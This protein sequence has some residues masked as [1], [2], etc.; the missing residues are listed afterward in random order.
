MN[1]WDKI[2][3]RGMT[4]DWQDFEARAAELPADFR[5]AWEQLKAELWAHGDFTGR[6]LS[7]IAD[8][9]LGLM[10]ATAAEGHSAEEALGEDIPGFCAALLGG[11]GAPDYREKWRRQ[12][13]RNVAR[14]L[15]KLG[16]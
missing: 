16:E 2:T 1:F 6:N 15:K 4:R 10:E 13:N 7:P 14:R 12:L 9:A 3:G 11:D 8:G 5:D